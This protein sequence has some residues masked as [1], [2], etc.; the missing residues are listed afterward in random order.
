MKKQSS[1]T[2]KGKED[3]RR[4]LAITARQLAI[5]A[6]EKEN[7][8]KKLVGTAKQLALIAKEQ[9]KIQKSLNESETRY[10][11]LFETAHDG[12]LLLHSETG[13]ITDVN[14]FLIKLLGY[15]K[16]EFLNKKL[17]EVGAFRNMRASKDVFKILQKDGFIRYDDL[18]LET[19]DG[20]S[21]DV[22]F[23][24]NSYMAGNTLV[25]Q[26]NIRDITERKKVDLIKETKRLLE[27]ERFKVE[28]IADA[29]HEL[30]T[31]L[32]I[33]KGNVDLALLRGGKSPKSALKAINYE[34][35]HLGGILSDLS[36]I[37]SKAWELKNRIAYEKVNLKSLIKIVVERTKALSYEKN[38]S[39]TAKNI[40]DLTI[41]G[42]KGYLEKMLVNLV[43]NS[44][45][46]GYKNGHT[47]IQTVQ[48]KGLVTINVIDDGIGISKEDLPHVFERFYRADKFHRSGGKSVGL[49]LAIVKW[50][51]E[52]HGGTVSV[53][54]RKDKQGTIFSVSLPVKNMSK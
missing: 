6:K 50:V 29:T 15:S 28:S 13:Q 21:I 49:G 17:W 23:V 25:I 33:M 35:K 31:P 26:C 20:H 9:S 10:R 5:S 24:S 1:T 48:S 34:I 54:N 36:L 3:I 37:T 46:Y 16:A 2:A 47:V 53:R 14:P 12:I 8:R 22:E 32:A 19:K 7:I 30:R 4:K 38:I 43:K 18:P 51:T 40:P 41:L 44:I 52:I 39:I 11:R 27:E 45:I 42:D